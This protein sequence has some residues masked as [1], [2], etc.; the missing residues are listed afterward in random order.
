MSSKDGIADP[1]SFIYTA[2][3]ERPEQIEGFTDRIFRSIA[4]V[5]RG[6]RQV[7]AL[8]KDTSKQ[9]AIIERAIQDGTLALREAKKTQ[10][11]GPAILKLT[12]KIDALEETMRTMSRFF[13]YERDEKG[14]LSGPSQGFKL[15]DVVLPE[16]LVKDLEGRM[17]D[18]SAQIQVL[19][20][21]PVTRMPAGGTGATE[22]FLL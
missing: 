22:P 18:L 11:K 7:T 5:E 8:L 17:E 12:G 13:D 10:G 19:K 9:Q 20:T 21:T 4:E 3:F 14:A 6:K 1:P 16:G 15:K 2:A